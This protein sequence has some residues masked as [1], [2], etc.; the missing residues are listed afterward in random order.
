VFSRWFRPDEFGPITGAFGAIGNAGGLI[1]A[2]P[3]AAV[4]ATLGWRTSFSA[5]A[6]LM[7]IATALVWVVVRDAPTAL[8]PSSDTGGAV[9]RG[10]GTVLRHRNT[11]LLGCYAFVTLGILAAMQGL[12]TVPY[13]RDIHGLSK[14]SA[15]NVLTLWG[16]GLI[17]GL[18]FWGYLADRVVRRRRAVLL[19][20]VAL[21]L[22]VWMLLMWRP[23][24]LPVPLVGGLFLWAGFVDGCWTPAYAQLKD[25]LPASVSGT[26]IGLLNFGFF[27]GAAAF[28]QITGAVLDMTDGSPADG[29]RLMF[30]LFTGALLVAALCLVLSRDAA[31][32]GST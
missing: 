2:G 7:V 3:L 5:M 23:D 20:S 8:P 24:T 30:G 9:L 29:Y 32:G 1:A 16:A 25:S 17:I 15:S 22:P 21:H 6:G 13:L 31:P 27:A 18:P 28:Q 14:Q 11:W 26:A 4:I 12:W 10:A 19:A